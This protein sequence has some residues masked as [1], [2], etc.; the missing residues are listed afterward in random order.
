MNYNFTELTFPSADGKNTVYAELYTPKSVTARGIVQLAHGMIDHPGRYKELADYLTAHGY[1]FAGNHHLGHGRTARDPEDFGFFAERDGAELLVKDMHTLNR[2]LR[3]TF[4]TLPLAVFGHSMGSF[5]TRKYILEHPHSMRAAVILGTSGPNP[6]VGMGIGVS[7]L[8]KKL[9]GPRHRSELVR[10]LAFG[11]Y[12]NRFPKEDGDS[13]WLTRDV[14]AV[15]DRATD[16]YTSFTFTVSA[17]IDLFGMIGEVNSS[18]WFKGYPKELPTLIV[19][20]E[21]DPVGNYGKGPR[22]VYSELMLSGCSRVSLKLY[23]EAR[24]ELFNEFGRE[25]FFIDLVS[26]LNG[27][28]G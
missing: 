10:S 3:D 14:A 20:G 22:K 4:P 1:V 24:H 21:A 8:L 7:K 16:P 23:P 2:Y 28:L 9:Y 11:S 15:A 6:L 17:Y 27:A 18:A 25:E 5:I 26:W 19:S 13:A 12:N